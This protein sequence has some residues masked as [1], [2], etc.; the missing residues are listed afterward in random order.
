[1]TA[2]GAFS[3]GDVLTAADL[4]AIGTWTT[5]TPTARFGANAVTFTQKYGRYSV[6]NKIVIL[7]VGFI[8][9]SYSGSGQLFVEGIP[10]AAYQKA[11][12]SGFTNPRVGFA[13]TWNGGAG[14]GYEGSA[15]YT[16]TDGFSFTG[17]GVGVWTN[18]VPVT[19]GGAVELYATLMYEAA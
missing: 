2:L 15:Y 9:F 18:T 7:Q 11:P 17:S 1:M 19:F 4:N 12:P 14:V 6:L 16:A 5:F 3:A 13:S 10:S 8:G